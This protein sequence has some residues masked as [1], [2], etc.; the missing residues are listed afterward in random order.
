MSDTLLGVALGLVAGAVWR[1]A[2]L[3]AWRFGWTLLGPYRAVEGS[4]HDN[5]LSTRTAGRALLAIVA[6]GAV[7]VAVILGLSLPAGRLVDSWPKF[8]LAWIIAFAASVFVARI[9]GGRRAV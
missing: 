4:V 3:R 9:T 2:F 1:A 8:R 7:S 6:A 5:R